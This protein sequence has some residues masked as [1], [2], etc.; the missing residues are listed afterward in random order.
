MDKR[1]SASTGP[2]SGITTGCHSAAANTDHTT[3]R[4][5]RNSATKVSSPPRGFTEGSKSPGE[6]RRTSRTKSE[7]TLIPNPSPLHTRPH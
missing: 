4:L 7:V 5:T 6:L 1:S 2:H 3:A